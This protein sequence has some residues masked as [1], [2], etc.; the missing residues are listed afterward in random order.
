MNVRRALT[1]STL[2]L[3]LFALNASAEGW[4]DLPAGTYDLRTH[5]TLSESG[6]P[7]RAAA[8]SARTDLDLDRRQHGRQE[9]RS[10]HPRGGDGW[11]GSL[12]HLDA[13]SATCPNRSCSR[14]TI[15]ITAAPGGEL[16]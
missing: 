13:P 9:Q 1:L 11:K 5:G 14:A 10:T 15:A 3:S 16:R 2:S 7:G 4:C 6:L 12:Y 8:R